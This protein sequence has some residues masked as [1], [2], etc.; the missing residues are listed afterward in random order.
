MHMNRFFHL[1]AGFRRMQ[2]TERWCILT[3]LSVHGRRGEM[4]FARFL[5]TS[6]GSGRLPPP[7]NG[8]LRT[9]AWPRRPREAGRRVGSFGAA[10]IEVP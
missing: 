8:V 9:G 6:G 4:F 10:E 3:H 1:D 7:P 2:R 5:H